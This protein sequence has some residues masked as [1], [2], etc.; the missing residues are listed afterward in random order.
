MKINKVALIAV[1]AVLA[2]T[3]FAGPRPRGGFHG[4]APR[5]R[6]APAFHHSHHHCG[7]AGAVI[8]A[9]IVGLVAGAILASEPA[10]QT[11]VHET[12]YVPQPVVQ[13]PVYVQQPVAQAQP[14]VAQAQP[15]VVQ[16]QPVYVQQPVVVQTTGV[17]VPPPPAPP[18]VYVAP[19]VIVRP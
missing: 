8:G 7:G 3:T 1:T 16:T 12:V 4:P 10:P 6:P 2:G 18:P 14:V 19:P 13:Q 17:Y 9:G 5:G 15:V 11:V